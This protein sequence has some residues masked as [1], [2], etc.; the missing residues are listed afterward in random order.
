MPNLRS[1]RALLRRTLQSV[2]KQ[3][4]RKE[5]VCAKAYL[6]NGFFLFQHFYVYSLKKLHFRELL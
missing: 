2:A 3:I 5:V 1:W 6:G 4:V